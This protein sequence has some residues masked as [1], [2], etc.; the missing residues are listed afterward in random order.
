MK[1]SELKKLN[2]AELTTRLHELRKDQV[3][4]RIQKATQ[5]EVKQTHLLGEVKKDIARVKT[6][7]NELARQ[8]S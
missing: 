8:A 1:V 7:M 3:K 2:A 5:Q 4:L 6:V